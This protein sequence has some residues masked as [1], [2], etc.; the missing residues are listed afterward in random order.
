LRSGNESSNRCFSGN[1]FQSDEFVTL[2]NSSVSVTQA[3]TAINNRF[4]YER[5]M[6]VRMDREAVHD[7][8]RPAE[9]P[10]G[11]RSIGMGFGADGNPLHDVARNFFCPFEEY[12]EKI[13]QDLNF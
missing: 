12:I 8:A 3:I 13:C 9:L 11:L 4:L 5:P 7:K 10:E 6:I 1:T 2:A